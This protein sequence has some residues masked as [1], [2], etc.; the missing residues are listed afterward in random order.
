MA[1]ICK[2]HYGQAAQE[3]NRAVPGNIAHVT[4][5][6]NMVRRKVVDH[7]DNKVSNGNECNNAGILE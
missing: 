7:E 6:L 1:R 5:V 4:S 2:N 3:G